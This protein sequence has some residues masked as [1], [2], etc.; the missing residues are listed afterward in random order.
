MTRRRN[1]RNERIDPCCILVAVPMNAKD[2]NRPVDTVLA[3]I[4]EKGGFQRVGSDFVREQAS[5]QLVLVRFGGSKFSSLC[6]FTKFMLCFIILV[7][8]AGCSKT[9]RDRLRFEKAE[10]V[11]EDAL[12]EI[13][14]TTYYTRGLI[15]LPVWVVTETTKEDGRQAV[16][17]TVERV[18]QES[19]PGYPGLQINSGQLVLADTLESY[20]FSI[21]DGTFVLNKF[22]E[23]V[24]VGSY[25]SPRP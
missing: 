22:P 5:T 14:V 4:L 16:L 1:T 8:H 19:E 24:Y 6:Q 20:R 17:F 13:V 12:R 23:C 3:P 9:P 7:L 15:G 11:Y 21:S 10:A 2:F 25:R 18:W